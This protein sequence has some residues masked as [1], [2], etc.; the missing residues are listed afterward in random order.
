M[1]ERVENK[2][3]KFYYVGGSFK[4]EKIQAL[5]E[6]HLEGDTL[7]I[8]HPKRLDTKG[9][10]NIIIWSN[11]TDDIGLDSDTSC[12]YVNISKL[13]KELDYVNVLPGIY[14]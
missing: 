10:G 4:F 11:G 5:F 2:Y 1:R 9:P 6:H 7:I 14:W 13:S 8:F 3:R 12:R